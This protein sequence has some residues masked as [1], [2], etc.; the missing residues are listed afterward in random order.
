MGML[1]YLFGAV[2]GGIAGIGTGIVA[3]G[4][5]ISGVIP[6]ALVGALAVKAFSG[7]SPA[8]ELPQ[9]VAVQVKRVPRKT[10]AKKVAAKKRVR[11]TLVKNATSK[12]V[13]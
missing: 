13:K 1:K 7:G 6:A 5:G 12:D 9:L 10:P 11:K 2:A 4:G 8:R 3:F